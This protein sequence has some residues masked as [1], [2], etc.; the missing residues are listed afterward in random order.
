MQ[1]LII[2]HFRPGRIEEI[3]RRADANGRMMPAGLS[4]LKSWVTCDLGTCY[5]IVETDDRKKIS[6]WMRQWE[7][8]VEFEVIEV[9][10]SEQAK[11]KA[12]RKG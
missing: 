4:Y 9:I 11:A 2:E 3:Y 12:L 5:Q 10:S 7:D 6:D 1:Y 8:L